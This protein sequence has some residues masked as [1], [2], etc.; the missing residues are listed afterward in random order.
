M[1]THNKKKKIKPKLYTNFF[2]K[3]TTTEVEWNENVCGWFGNVMKINWTKQLSW[4][5]VLILNSEKKAHDLIILRKR[6]KKQEIDG[7]NNNKKMFLI[8][9]VDGNIFVYCTGL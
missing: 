7:S 8:D 9:T 5:W 6:K 2:R 4:G 3:E 1:P